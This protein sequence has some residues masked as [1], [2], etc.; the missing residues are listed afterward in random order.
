[1]F[2]QKRGTEGFVKRAD[3]KFDWENSIFII[4]YIK[5]RWISC[6]SIEKIYIKSNLISIS[7]IN[8]N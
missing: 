6:I 2:I 5:I 4:G 1:M 7:M 3:A 8:F